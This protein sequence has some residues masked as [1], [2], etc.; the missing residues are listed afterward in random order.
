MPDANRGF[1]MPAPRLTY[2]PRSARKRSPS[3]KPA[4][5]GKD[6]NKGGAVLAACSDAGGSM[7]GVGQEC[8]HEGLAY[9][10]VV[11]ANASIISG[12][13]TAASEAAAR[14]TCL[15]DALAAAC[16]P[17]ARSLCVRPLA[18]SAGPSLVLFPVCAAA[19][20]AP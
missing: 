12:L 3:S 18:P 2:R 1:D 16:R 20:L 17:P 15:S 8:W 19:R 13:T 7:L 10:C 11:D 5:V 14:E 6:V 9:R 4:F